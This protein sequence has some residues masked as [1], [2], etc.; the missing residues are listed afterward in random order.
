MKNKRYRN[1]KIILHNSCAMQFYAG[2][3]CIRHKSVGMT[4]AATFLLSDA[5]ALCF[6]FSVVVWSTSAETAC[7][8]SFDVP[9]MPRD[10]YIQHGDLVLG[11]LF[12]I[13]RHDSTKPSRCSSRLYGQKSFQ[14]LEAVRYAIHLINNRTDI[15]P[16]ITLGFTFLDDCY[17]DETALGRALQY[18]PVGQGACGSA[19]PHY[20]IIGMVAGTNSANTI[21]AT[22]VLN[23]FQIPVV[24][25]SATSEVL[26]KTK[27]SYFMRVVPPDMYQAQVIVDI[28]TRF[29]W[30]YLSTIY[31]EG[32]YGESGIKRVK[33][34]AK[35]RGYCIAFSRE[36]SSMTMEAEYD[37]II[38]VLL[39]K[40]NARA[41][42][43][44][45]DKTGGQGV[46]AA[47]KRAGV[48]NTFTWIASDSVSPGDLGDLQ[49]VA[50]GGF[51]VQ[52]QTPHAPSFHDYYSKLNPTNNNYS[53]FKEWWQQEFKCTWDNSSGIDCSQSTDIKMT[54]GYSSKNKAPLFLG[55]T[56]VFAY[57]ADKMI[58]KECPAAFQNKSLLNDCVSG[59]RLLPF[60]KN[61]SLD[62]TYGHI[63]F[64]ELGDG[65]GTYLIEH[66][67]NVDSVLTSVHVGQWDK[68]TQTLT[69]DQSLLDWT[70]PTT[71]ESVCSHPC[72]P[73]EFRIPLDLPCCWECRKCRANEIISNNSCKECPMY[74]WPDNSISFCLEI[75]PV[76]FHAQD[77]VALL[78][79]TF[80]VVGLLTTTGIIVFYVIKRNEKL[81]KASSREL[82]FTILV[83]AL[84][85]Y[86]GSLA[87]IFKPGPIVCLWA[88]FGTSVSFTLLY[89][90]LLTKTNRVHRIFDAGKRGIKKPPSWVS[91]RSQVVIVIVL[92]LIQ[93]GG[94]V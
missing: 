92:I 94:I 81:I 49:P 16:N 85:A 56:D 82:S 31:S 30:T 22:N 71:P 15:L 91:S 87:Y 39:Q 21:S 46:L 77:P 27:Y 19:T 75:P 88:R 79:L 40:K 41:V 5:I 72:G 57:A 89:A 62:S 33:I 78:C 34:L 83:G 54:K 59:A 1:E 7:V 65:E 32:S 25:G 52:L 60:L 50:V 42:V 23:L 86:T 70:G 9:A 20:N 67:R 38:R 69:M 18:V 73:G 26:S 80:A 76:Y 45:T 47:A 29:N 24:S 64:D 3:Y 10:A 2:G 44:F 13:H 58:R 84:F 51:F 37:D 11:G 43:M 4:D 8:H 93:V 35:E 36:V 55:V 66:L 6:I 28:L 17:N 53:W 63:E 61:T 74:T 14:Y 90:P 48:N 68:K 12:R